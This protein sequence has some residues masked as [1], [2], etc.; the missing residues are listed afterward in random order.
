[1]DLD[2]LRRD[3]IWITA[4]S[5]DGDS[6]LIGLPE[7]RGIRSDKDIRKSYLEGRFGGTPQ[8]D[9]FALKE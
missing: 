5:L 2:Y 4:K 1:M 6:A 9:G 8:L 7:Y 3:E